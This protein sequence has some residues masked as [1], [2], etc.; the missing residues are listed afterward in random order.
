VFI[1]DLG[2]LVRRNA[3]CSMIINCLELEDKNSSA[4]SSTDPDSSDK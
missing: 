1:D 2:R 3:D 4:S